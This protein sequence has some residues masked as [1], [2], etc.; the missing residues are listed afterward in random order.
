MDTP[1]GM[2]DVTD[3]PDLKILTEAG[4]VVFYHIGFG[5]SVGGTRLFDQSLSANRNRVKYI[6][7]QGTA[8]HT[9]KAYINVEDEGIECLMCDDELSTKC[10]HSEEAGR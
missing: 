7:Y 8:P 10:D 4:L 2:K 6:E 3:D 1:A 9:Y 5:G